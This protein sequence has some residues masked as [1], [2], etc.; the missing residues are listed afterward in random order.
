MDC[1]QVADVQR[2]AFD[3]GEDPSPKHHRGSGCE[4]DSHVDAHSHDHGH[5]CGGHHHPA[6]S[7]GDASS[8]EG[9]PSEVAPGKAEGSGSGGSGGAKGWAGVPLMRRPKSSFSHHTKVASTLHQL[10][11]DWSEEGKAERDRCYAPI[12]EEL[13]RRIPIT[14]SNRCACSPSVYVCVVVDPGARLL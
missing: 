9:A 7:R 14:E 1:A 13:E 6:A 2:M 5:E 10:V 11:R 4:A 12:L 8:A 3:D